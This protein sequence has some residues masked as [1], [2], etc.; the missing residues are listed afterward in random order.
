[1]IHEERRPQPVF[2]CCDPIREVCEGGEPDTAH[3]H[4]RAR[5]RVTG[6]RQRV[7][8]SGR[9]GAWMIRGTVQMIKPWIWAF[10]NRVFRITDA[11]S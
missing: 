11:H 1:M 4:A 7:Y 3:D 5:A 9:H 8:W 6:Y 2:T 10:D